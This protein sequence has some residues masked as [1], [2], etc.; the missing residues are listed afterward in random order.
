MI[1]MEYL[2]MYKLYIDFLKY[3]LKLTNGPGYM[4][5]ISFGYS[6]QIFRLGYDI[7]PSYLE[8]LVKYGIF[9]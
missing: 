1:N 3:K 8:L 9:K 7:N 5:G 6:G 2:K 4:W